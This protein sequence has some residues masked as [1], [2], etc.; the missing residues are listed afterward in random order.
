MTSEPYNQWY[1]LQV[2]IVT[3]MVPYSGLFHNHSM[4]VSIWEQYKKVLPSFENTAPTNISTRDM[5]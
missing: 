3:I 2:F 4:E 5:Q 1:I